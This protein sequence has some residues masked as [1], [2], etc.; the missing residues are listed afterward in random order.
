MVAEQAAH[1]SEPPTGTE[2]PSESLEE[3]VKADNTFSPLVWHVGQKA[4]SLRQ[5]ILRSNSNLL[6]QFEQKYS[7]IGIFFPPILFYTLG[8]WKARV[9]KG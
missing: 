3:A 1:L 5:P 8:E 2:T 7:Y 6:L 9:I 4:S